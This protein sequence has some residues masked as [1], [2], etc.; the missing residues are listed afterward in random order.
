MRPTPPRAWPAV[1]V[2]AATCALILI[3]AAAGAV[4][5][6]P[7]T[8]MP[9]RTSAGHPASEAPGTVPAKLKAASIT[10]L[11]ATRG[12]ILGSAPCGQTS[13][14]TVVATS[15]GGRTWSL[16]GS[17]PVP[18]ASIDTPSDVGVAGIRFTS[19]AVG[20]AFGP[21]LFRT[22]NGGRSWAPLPVPGHGKQVLALA[23]TGAGV[24]AVVSPCAEFAA[25]CKVKTLSFWRAD[26]L[27]GQ[28]WTRIPLHLGLNSVA[29][30]AAFGKTVYV[31][32]PGQRNT[33]DASTD[34]R[35]FSARPSP[36]N[37]AQGL[38]LLQAAPTSA[39]GVALLCDG[40]PGISKATKTVYRS[41]DTGRTDVSAGTTGALGIDADLA[42]SASGSLLVASWSNGSW[43]YLNNS[44][45]TTWTT[46]LALGDNGAGFRDLAFSSSKVAWVV[47]GPVSFFPA[48]FGRL[49]VTRDGGQHWQLVTP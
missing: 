35:H 24:W 49:Y 37:T 33:L 21:A 18:L 29:S 2:A 48:D 46:P 38:G 1:A 17:M 12:W 9:V 4:T 22:G 45:K 39:T 28:N 15:N 47:Y 26:S 32:D 13:C 25:H 30:V 16:A 27:T 14:A 44:H 20:W 31:V 11:S 7:G 5:G 8:A 43:I 34:G 10:W 40:D 3:P 41:A 6:G 36:C 23:T 42:A 19:A